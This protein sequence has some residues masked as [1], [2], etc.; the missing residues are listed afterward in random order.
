MDKDIEHYIQE[1]EN[2]I[3]VV[4]D[5]Q[6]MVQGY[7]GSSV[8][9][10]LQRDKPKLFRQ[11]KATLPLTG[12]KV[13]AYVNSKDIATSTMGNTTDFNVGGPGE[14]SFTSFVWTEVDGIRSVGTRPDDDERVYIKNTKTTEMG[15]NNTETVVHIDKLKVLDTFERQAGLVTFKRPVYIK[16]KNGV[17]HSF[18]GYFSWAVL[19]D[20]YPSRQDREAT[21]ITYIVTD[22]DSGELWCK[23]VNEPDIEVRVDYWGKEILRARFF[24]NDHP[25]VPDG[26]DTPVAELNMEMP[27][28][29]IIK[30]I[31]SCS[32][33]DVNRPTEI[34]IWSADLDI[35]V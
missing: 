17:Q 2:H 9:R 23:S 5:T 35:Q 25:Y 10:M 26:F 24:K 34:T 20:R 33:S 29:G 4:G 28:G 8:V 14:W 22:P 11:I 16:L 13:D 19:S 32:P 21:T 1:P 30:R 31:Y 7:P 15:Q 27:D 18:I 6:Y 3:Y 12:D